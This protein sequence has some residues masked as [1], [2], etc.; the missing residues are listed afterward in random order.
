MHW[1][2][3]THETT[4][5]DLG[6][7][8]IAHQ[9]DLLGNRTH[10]TLPTGQHIAWHYYGSGHLLQINLDH[11][12][13]SE[14]TRD[15]LYQEIHR[16]QGKLATRQH[17]DALGRLTSQQVGRGF[18]P[19]IDTGDHQAYLNDLKTQAYH[20]LKLTRHYSY[21]K[22][23]ELDAID[24]ARRGLTQ[25]H[26]DKLGRILSTHAPNLKEQFAFD[27]A[28]NLIP[29][30]QADNLQNGQG[31]VQD[32]RLK[33]YADKRY[34]YDDFGNLT[35]KKIGSH[36]TIALQYDAE[37]QLVESVVNKHGVEQT[38]EYRY[39]PFGR[40]IAKQDAFNHTYFLWDGNRLLS[41]FRGSKA[42][43]YIYEQDG[44]VPI[45]Q[46][47]SNLD[48]AKGDKPYPLKPI[49]A[50]SNELLYYHVDHLGTPRELSDSEGNYVWAAEYKTWGNTL[51]IEYPELNQKAEQA[52]LKGQTIS[53]EEWKQDYTQNI[54]FQ[55]QYYDEE[56][57]LHYNRF[58]YYDPD[59]GRFISQDPIGA[60]GWK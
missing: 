51:K 17:Y 25:Y 8:A 26:Y 29:L 28:H 18:T 16:T 11:H 7:Y 38:T 19:L 41:E 48:K 47:I 5:S 59:I 20:P 46:V 57:G 13:V 31:L 44:F 53:I 54:R 6:Q 3:L 50:T 36:T 34:Q 10:T 14:F 58:R 52:R 37:H 42:K 56:T 49:A 27:P 1:A 30:D 22:N 60:I 2:V 24:D 9:Y 4:T 32:N 40:R 55:G 15:T 35:E 33:V 23:G 43:T 39:D 45:A 12:I 21:T